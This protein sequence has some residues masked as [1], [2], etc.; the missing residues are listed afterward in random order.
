MQHQPRKR[1]GQN[2]LQSENVI[3]NIIN[4]INPEINDNLI[5]I[6]PGLGALTKEILPFVHKLNVIEID[7]D[8]AQKLK[9]IFLADNKLIIHNEDALHFDFLKLIENKNTTKLRIFGNLPYNI[10]TPLIFHV[11]KFIKQIQDVHFMVQNEMAERL[12][13]KPDTKAYGRLTVMVQYFCAVEKLFI[14]P[15][16]AFTPKPKVHSAIVRLTPHQHL[17]TPVKDMALLQELVAKSFLTRRKTIFN[18]LKKIL[19]KEDFIKLAIDPNLRAENISVDNYVKITN[20]LFSK[21]AT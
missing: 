21:G 8:L 17:S 16:E 13:A 7:R 9:I 10:T 4:A 20:F 14:V 1:F 19:T 5:E 11:L 6:G 2:F 12:S 15:P 18:N 3:Q